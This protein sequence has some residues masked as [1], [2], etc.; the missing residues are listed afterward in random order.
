MSY[1]RLYRDKFLHQGNEWFTCMAEH[2]HK[3]ITDSHI[4]HFDIVLGLRSLDV[5]EI[6]E[7]HIND[8]EK[9]LIL[10]IYNEYRIGNLFNQDLWRPFSDPEAITS[11]FLGYRNMFIYT[12]SGGVQYYF[13]LALKDECDDYTLCKDC[14]NINNRDIHFTAAYYG[15]KNE[16]YIKLQPDDF[17]TI[18]SDNLIPEHYWKD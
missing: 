1:P 6:K 17:L 3:M 4:P 8:I 12:Y 2:F 5:D 7:K 15:W 13:Q 16:N 9:E 10:W 14:N 11:M 18:L